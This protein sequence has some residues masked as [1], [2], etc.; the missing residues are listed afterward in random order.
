[1]SQHYKG[2]SR[3]VRQ[4][5]KPY[6]QCAYYGHEDHEQHVFQLET[7]YKHG[8]V[9]AKRPAE[10]GGEYEFAVPRVEFAL[11]GQVFVFLRYQQHYRVKVDGDYIHR[12]YDIH[13]Q[14]IKSM[15]QK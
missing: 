7:R 14:H 5:D 10:Q 4:N 1:M 9:N 15:P 3:T 12:E 6:V 2:K 11:I 8:H 13:Q